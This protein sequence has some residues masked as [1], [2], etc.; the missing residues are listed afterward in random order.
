MEKI[1][2][3]LGVDEYLTTPPKKPKAF[4]KV[5]NQVYPEDGRNIQMDVMYLP[6][7]DSGYKYVLTAVDLWSD[8]C[9]AQPLKDLKSG[10]ILRAAQAM[11]KRGVIQKPTASVAV[12]GGNEFKKE[13]K[14]F[15]YRNNIL[16]K[17]GAP[18]RKTQSGPV[19]AFNGQLGRL[20]IGV[21]NK[22]E[23][24]RGKR[25]TNWDEY[26]KQIVDL[27]NE[28]RTE[29]RKK[30]KI[31]QTGGSIKTKSKYKVGDL[32]HYAL[33]Y[34]RDYISAKAS[35]P[36]FRVGDVRYSLEVKRVKHVFVYPADKVKY[37]YMLSGLTNRTYTEEQLKPSRERAA[38]EQEQTYLVEKLLKRR[39]RKGKV[40]YLVHWKGFKAKDR[41][42]EGRPSLL[43]DVPALVQAFDNASPSR[44]K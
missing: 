13:F 34:P 15:F 22:E 25:W 38:K 12:D 30:L 40:E 42:W 14:D 19:E 2:K 4:T 17:K 44:K 23:E 29:R 11:F 39:T 32:V 21:M 26:L 36:K 24:A 16:L 8:E 28:Y 37:R 41:T 33:D 20:L 3:Q 31:D 7:T 10:S 6:T 27:L 35:T 9:D 1:L 18:Y 43:Q 5:K